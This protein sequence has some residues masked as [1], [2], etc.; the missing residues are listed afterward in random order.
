M[1]MYVPPYIHTIARCRLSPAG[2][3]LVPEA[4]RGTHAGARGVQDA[5]VHHQ[6]GAIVFH[7]QQKCGRARYLALSI[8]LVFSAGVM[9]AFR[10]SWARHPS[11]RINR[12]REI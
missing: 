2:D 10:L 5:V 1:L 6:H 8:T 7:F 3:V 12:V 11:A 4:A 9:L